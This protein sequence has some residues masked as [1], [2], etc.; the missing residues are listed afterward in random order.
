MIKKILFLFTISFLLFLF[1]C[2]FEE[3]TNFVPENY[4]KNLTNIWD[5]SNIN[6]YTY[7]NS[8]VVENG[9]AKL[10]TDFFNINWKYRIPITINNSSNTE[11]LTDYQ[12]KINIDSSE[13]EFWN[14]IE[15]NGNSIRFTD[16][17][18][19]TQLSF[20]IEKF[21]YTNQSAIIWVKVP[22]IAASSTKTI[23]M[24]YG[25]SE[26]TNA[27]DG[28]STFIFFDNFEDGD[29]GDWLQYSSG[30]VQIA[31][32]PG[33]PSGISSSYSLLKT[34]N[35]DPNGGYKLIGTTLGLGYI[36]EGRIF[37]SNY[38]GGAADRLAIED[39]SFSGYGI[40]IN[41]SSDYILIESRDAGTATTISSTTPA[42]STDPEYSWYFFSFSVASDSTMA[43]YLYYPDQTT[44]LVSVTASDSTYSSF[45][46]VVIHGGYEYLIDDLR[47][48]KYTSPEPTTTLGNVET[49]YSN[50][51]PALIPNN[52]VDYSELL[53]FIQTTGTNNEGTIKYQ[54][55]NDKLTWYYW[56]GSYWI[57]ASN[58]SETN[59][60]DEINAHLNEFND[61]IGKGTFYFKAFF[62]S[63]GI[64]Q[65]ELDQVSLN[66][67]R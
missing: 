61:E 60:S 27:S 39:S 8:I 6:D 35:S 28:E 55:S 17:D 33:P 16:E 4:G 1:S 12:I 51:S 5:F 11:S 59:T 52:G 48:R 50:N 41:H 36:L 13:S 49:R 66:Y 3:E 45:D 37:R 29:A 23:Y 15:N 34:L 47:I 58:S 10:S 62:I 24:Y 53:E 67:K 40:Q 22:N 20:W 64:Q 44:L 19:T 42:F 9:I 57:N 54:I 21:D 31:S 7:N 2:G 25:N 56:N 46:R 30:G 63:D 65:V 14:A 26:A 38:N 32:D 43:F 18:G